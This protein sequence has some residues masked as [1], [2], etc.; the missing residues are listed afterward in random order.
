M[1]F[2]TASRTED[3]SIVVAY[4]PTPREIT[5]KMTSLKGPV[6]ARWFDPVT[7]TFFVI[8]GGPFA[9]TGSRRFTPPRKVNDDDGDGDWVLLLVASGTAP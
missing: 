8:P 5:V 9:N 6:M 1:D 7:G 2:C 4:M 3:G